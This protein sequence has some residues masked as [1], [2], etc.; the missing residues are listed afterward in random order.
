MIR[1][2][3]NQGYL[4]YVLGHIPTFWK[5]KHLL[6]D[7]IDFVEKF[8]EIFINIDTFEYDFVKSQPFDIAKSRIEN[9]G[10]VIILIMLQDWRPGHYLE[11]AGE[12]II[13]WKA[14]DYYFFASSIPY[15]ES[16]VGD[17]IK[18]TL[19]LYAT[20]QPLTSHYHQNNKLYEYNIHE[21]PWIIDNHLIKRLKESIHHNF[22]NPCMIYLGN[23]N[24]KQLET[25]K[26]SEQTVKHINEKGLDIYLYE[27]MCAYQKNQKVYYE[28]GTKHTE[29]FY[30]EFNRVSYDDLRADE[31][32]SIVAFAENNNA[33]DIRVHV[34]EFN[35]EK[36]FPYYKDK[37]KLIT[38]DICLR[39]GWFKKILDPNFLNNKLT[40]KFLSLNY[41]YTFHR[42]LIAA[43]LVNLDSKISWNFKCDYEH[44]SHGAFFNLEKPIWNIYRDH[45][46][47]GVETLN[48]KSPFLLDFNF[49]ESSVIDHNY[50]K[51]PFPQHRVINK[52]DL[53]AIEEHYKHIF[54]DVI[55]ETRF[56]Q[57]MATYSEK[58]H[59]AIS[60]FKPFIVVGPPHSLS[61]LKSNGFKTF[62]EFWDES[63]DTVENHEKRLIKIFDLITEINKL[64][65]EQ[66]NELY[67]RMMP[68]LRFNQKLLK[69]KLRP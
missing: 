6:D 10:E 38:D 18:Y 42:N 54:C 48:E 12:G 41:R 17:D 4:N 20:L 5:D 59:Q 24:I 16:N 26:Y 11:I 34:N 7:N 64:S 30:S 21:R 45:I 32:D 8:K 36:Y 27:P 49:R 53:F 15:A 25:L 14:G 63:Y 23:E 37:F 58:I 28:G 22:D 61:Y 39:G 44:M 68:V 69:T 65:I 3:L 51:N 35:V 66:C 57:P 29:W 46:K 67:Q 1:I 40:T 56:A 31:L 50:F 9:K 43:F 60:Y 55:C 33:N 52:I 62:N 13:N 2:D 47:N 19:K